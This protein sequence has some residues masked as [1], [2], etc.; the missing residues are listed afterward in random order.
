MYDGSAYIG[1]CLALTTRQLKTGG[2]LDN[3]RPHSWRVPFEFESGGIGYSID[4][5]HLSLDPE[6]RSGTLCVEYRWKDLHDWIWKWGS[7]HVLLS[8]TACTYWWL[9]WWFLSGDGKRQTK[10]YFHDGHFH[11]R[12]ALGLRYASQH[13]TSRR[14]VLDHI[15]G[16][17]RQRAIQMMEDITFPFRNGKPTRKYRRLLKHIESTRMNSSQLDAYVERQMGRLDLI[18]RRLSLFH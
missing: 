4:T 1:D 3:F 7:T 6:D 16:Y 9:R 14:Q 17:N 8:A 18:E 2:H 5:Y 13:L 12:G 11:A 10:L 15:S